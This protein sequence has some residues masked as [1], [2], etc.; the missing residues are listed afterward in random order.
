ME[1][2]Q[3]HYLRMTGSAVLNVNPNTTDAPA[4]RPAVLARSF[5]DA[6]SPTNA[7]PN[8]P[9]VEYES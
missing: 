8:E 6:T 3:R 1:V 2:R 5:W 4:A 9:T 7:Q